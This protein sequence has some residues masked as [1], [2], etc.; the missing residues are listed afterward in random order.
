VGFAA[1]FLTV[2]SIQ[3][4]AAPNLFVMEG[5]A[6]LSGV[7]LRGSSGLRRMTSIV[8]PSA[9]GDGKAVCA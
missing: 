8:A 9:N 6:S 5:S 2:A 7:R 1:A 4:E 3:T